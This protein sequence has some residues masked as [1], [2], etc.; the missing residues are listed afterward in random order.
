MVNDKIIVLVD[1]IQRLANQIH[2]YREENTETDKK[3]NDQYKDV[4]FYMTNMECK[5]C[6]SLIKE[7]FAECTIDFYRYS[8]KSCL[9]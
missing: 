3:D 2:V 9:S 8:C 5:I 7:C 4:C 6:M 1:M